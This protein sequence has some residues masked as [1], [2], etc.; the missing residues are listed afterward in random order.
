MVNTTN[1]TTG[2]EIQRHINILVAGE[3]ENPTSLDNSNTWHIVWISMLALII[4][5]LLVLII[6]RIWR[7]AKDTSL[8]L[9]NGKVT[10]YTISQAMNLEEVQALLKKMTDEEFRLHEIRKLYRE[11]YQN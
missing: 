6:I 11:K 8:K 9:D 10:N 5:V 1:I 4:L 2:L 3:E 7:L